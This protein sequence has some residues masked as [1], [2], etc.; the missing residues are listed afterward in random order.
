MGFCRR[1]KSLSSFFVT[2][3]VNQ[4]ARCQDFRGSL[5]KDANRPQAQFA[6]AHPP[7]VRLARYLVWRLGWPQ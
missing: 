6:V 5:G 3:Y 4:R 7:P 2:R 1:K